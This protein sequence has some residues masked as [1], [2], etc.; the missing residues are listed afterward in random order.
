MKHSVSVTASGSSTQGV[1]LIAD[2]T[3]GSLGMLNEM[4]V[5][6]GYTV[7]VAMDGLQ[8]LAVAERMMPD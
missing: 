7:L 6:A 8:A 2:D 5:Q 4:L 1:V 3:I